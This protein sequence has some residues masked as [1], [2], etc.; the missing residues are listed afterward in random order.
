MSRFE[1]RWEG[2]SLLAKYAWLA[3]AKQR[4][5]KES[6]KYTYSAQFPLG[7]MYKK[8]QLIF[9][10][11]VFSST[12][13]FSWRGKGIMCRDKTIIYYA[14]DALLVRSY[15]PKNG[16]LR[17]LYI[18]FFIIIF[19]KSLHAFERFLKPAY[20]VSLVVSNIL[21]FFLCSLVLFIDFVLEF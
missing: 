21:F 6:K 4:V 20:C 1:E 18:Y 13:R 15:D 16:R 9:S 2:V 10:F 12:W 14:L 5:K 19:R 17:Y 7:L 3:T 8:R 11:L